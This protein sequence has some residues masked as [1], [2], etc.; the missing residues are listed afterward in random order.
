MLHAHR[1]HECGHHVVAESL[2]SISGT[3]HPGLSFIAPSINPLYQISRMEDRFWK[4]EDDAVVLKHVEDYGPQQWGLIPKIN[5]G[6][7]KSGKACRV[8]WLEHLQEGIN[9]A[10]FTEEEAELVE[11]LQ[12]RF[13]NRW[14][15]GGGRV[16]AVFGM[17]K[18]QLSDACLAPNQAGFS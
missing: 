2:E 10:P 15:S 11:R 6:F 16:N 17:L 18:Q 12:R 8:R 5:E 13:G 7:T 9:K 4:P 14:V 3:T 1:L